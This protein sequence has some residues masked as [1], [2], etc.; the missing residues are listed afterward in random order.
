MHRIINECH[1]EAWRLLSEYRS[2]LDDLARA[3]LEHET[4]DETQILEVTGLTPVPAVAD[5]I[6][7]ESA[8]ERA[9]SAGLSPIRTAVRRSRR[10]IPQ[11]L[12]DAHIE[13][14][15]VDHGKP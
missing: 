10:V 8:P 1:D 9:R 6:G 4:L 15:I 11:W 12:T 7:R 14:A 5:S 3:L 2:Q 13:T